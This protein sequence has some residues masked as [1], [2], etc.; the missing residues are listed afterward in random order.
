MWGQAGV[1]VY[2]ST[3]LEAREQAQVLPNCSYPS[4]NWIFPWLEIQQ[5]DQA[6][7]CST[8]RSVYVHFPSNL[9]ASVFCQAWHLFMWVLGINITQGQVLERDAGTHSDIS[10][11]KLLLSVSSEIVLYFWDFYSYFQIISMLL[12]TSHIFAFY[13]HVE[14]SPLSVLMLA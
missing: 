14:F 4:W 13:W 1:L 5:V 3:I 10:T 11:T 7:V 8:Q 6:W 9:F 2:A 12:S